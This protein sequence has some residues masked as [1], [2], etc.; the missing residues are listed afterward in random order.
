MTTPPASDTTA[1]PALVACAHGT[2]DPAG[3]RAVAALREQI[4]ALL[5]EVEVLEASVDVEHPS[6]TEVMA[7]LAA[8]RR[9]GVVVPLLL[10]AG[11]HVY[12][13]VADAVAGTDGAATATGALGPDDALVAL[14]VRRLS[15]A[16]AEP[17]EPVVLAAAGSSDARAVAD[18]AAVAAR[19]A[20]AWGGPVEVGYLS[21]ATPRV[22]DV[23][24]RRRAAAPTGRVV[25]AT[26]LL[27]PGFFYDRLVAL[28]PDPLGAPL[29]PDPAIARIAAAR[30]AGALAALPG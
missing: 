24:T 26:Y 28:G 10:S 9:P 25:V 15:E 8:R 18:C 11:Y 5:P 12:H 30:Y 17:G 4:A 6:L 21:A 2:N 13:D 22:D 7:D 3:R 27:A 20:D 19:L 23:I 14:L 1:R 16:G 29:A